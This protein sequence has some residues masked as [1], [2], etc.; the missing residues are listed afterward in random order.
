MGTRNITKIYFGGELKVC[1]YGQWDGYPTT[2]LHHIVEFLKDQNKVS[3]LLEVL[4]KVELMAELGYEKHYALP[5]AD[6]NKVFNL[7]L[8]YALKDDDGNTIKQSCDLTMS[9]KINYVIT[10][11]GMDK[12]IP[13]RFLLETRDTGYQIFDVLTT[14][15]AKQADSIPLLSEE[16]YEN[17]WDIEAKNIIDFDK[18]MIYA[19]WHGKSRE[20][21]F[22]HLPDLEELDAFE[23]EDKE[24]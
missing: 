11:T 7:L 21:S 1:Q 15:A 9:E 20:Y 8:N 14:F 24:E 16:P 10:Q 2:A 17:S 5:D 6:F 13:F 3:S 4:P 18:R 22:D 19:W 23:K 12:A